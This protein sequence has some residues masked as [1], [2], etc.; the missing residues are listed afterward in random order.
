MKYQEMKMDLFSV[1]DSYYL[2]HCI[3]ADFKMGAGIATEF[4]RR[5]DTKNKLFKDYPDY[6]NNFVKTKIIGDCLLEDGVLNLITKERY[7]Y[8]PTY[9]SIKISLDKMKE[10]CIINDIKKVAMPL[11][12]CGLD[13]LEWERVKSLL[14]AIFDDLDIEILVCK[15]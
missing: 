10:I 11:I 3:S 14:I 13:K 8:K 1:D 4:V 5:F 9:K 15:K 2:A 7:Y 12:G 6:L